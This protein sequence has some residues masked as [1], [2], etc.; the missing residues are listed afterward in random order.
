MRDGAY[1]YGFDYATD[2]VGSSIAQNFS[3]VAGQAYTLV[4]DGKGLGG[5]GTETLQVTVGDKIASYTFQAGAW[6]TYTLTFTALAASTNLNFTHV[7]GGIGSDP[8]I[9]NVRVIADI[10]ANSLSGGAGNDTIV[11]GAGADTVAGGAGADY[12]VGGAGIDTV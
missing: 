10:T 6:N 1:G 3:T 5:S 8:V 9:D 4:F 11:G 12:L 2:S 7:S